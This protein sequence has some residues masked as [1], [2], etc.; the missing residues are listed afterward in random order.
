MGRVSVETRGSL[1]IFQDSQTEIYPFLS[2]LNAQLRKKIFD[3]TP[4]TIIPVSYNSGAITGEVKYDANGNEIGKILEHH[5]EGRT[6]HFWNMT[7]PKDPENGIFLNHPVEFYY[8]TEKGGVRAG[9][10]FPTIG[11]SSRSMAD[12]EFPHDQNKPRD[13]V[14]SPKQRLLINAAFG[15]KLPA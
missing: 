1:D 8:I 9:F 15:T 14:F 13:K 5:D 6:D 7:T 11:L 4:G 10:R 12:F 3:D 2:D